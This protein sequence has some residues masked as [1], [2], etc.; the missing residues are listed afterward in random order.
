MLRCRRTVIWLACASWLFGACAHRSASTPANA[1]LSAPLATAGASPGEAQPA[2]ETVTTRE[3]T[4]TG[5]G[6]SFK[7]FLAYPANASGKRPGVLIMHEWWGLNDY[8]RSRARK[9]AELGYVALAADLYGDGRTAE[10]PA[11]AQKLA[12]ELMSSQAESAR[13]AD[14]ALTALKSDPQVDP[15]KIA[16]IGYCMGGAVVLN[17]A[18][19]GAADLDAVASFH[20]MYA[21]E[22]PM[23]KG[24]FK[25][26]I[27]VAHGAADSFTSPEQIVAFK[28]ELDAAGARYEFVSYQ[29]A[30][31]GF[32]NP[33]ATATG[34][35]EGL[36]I[37]Y[38]AEADAAS[39]SKLQEVLAKAFS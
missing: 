3:L 22:S 6:T 28:K 4:Y 5:G 38:D 2:S 21:T 35:R 27:F 11:D 34:Q 18:R 1:E 30:K 23:P 17:L 14:A 31:H 29:G 32:S 26:A 24:A 12:G 36:D 25:G 37:A 15:E 13:R 16:A 33:E 19:R 39:W 10:H 8:A 7:G 20:G 9:L